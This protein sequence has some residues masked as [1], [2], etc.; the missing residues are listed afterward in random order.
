MDAPQE[1]RVKPNPH[2][3]R[4]TRRV[5]GIDQDGAPLTASVTVERPLTLYLN[6]RE[7]VTMMTIGDF[8]D[9]LAVGYLLNQNMLRPGDEITAIEFDAEIDT[10]VV[11]TGHQTDFEDKLKKKTLTSGCA[12]GT[13]FGDVMESFDATRL[14]V[15][16]VLR[17]SWLYVL[18]KKINTAPSLYL[19]AGAIHGCVLCQED[20]P[21][22]YMEDVGR[23]N[24]VDKIAGYMFLEGIESAD[25]IFYTT[26][27]L[28]SEMVIKAV[29]MGIPILISR[30]GFTAWGV[31]LARQVGLTLIGRCRGKRFLALAG[32]GRIVFDAD[33]SSVTEEPRHLRR[34]AATR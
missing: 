3:P 8:P 18:L 7:I 1:F 33:P 20:R 30:S 17:T 26:G 27:R 23:H 28:T 32:E 4:L 11:R 2:D 29:Q 25:K 16:A 19:E 15:D 24:A 12:Q 9:Y 14:P 21:L 31:E 13:V 22:I 10:V 6:S 5:A 34:K